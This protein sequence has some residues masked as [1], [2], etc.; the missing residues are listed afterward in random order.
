MDDV[1]TVSAVTGG[2]IFGDWL[3]NKEVIDRVK[4]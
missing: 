3:G 2:G 4:S 1:A